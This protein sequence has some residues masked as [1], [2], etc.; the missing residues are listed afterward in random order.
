MAPSFA[1]IEEPQTNGA[2]ERFN[3]TLKE[4]AIWGRVFLNLEDV[5]EAVGNFV[6]THNEH[7]MVEKLGFLSPMQARREWGIQEAA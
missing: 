2:A 7:W 5:R 6:A 3:R 4:Q 1:F